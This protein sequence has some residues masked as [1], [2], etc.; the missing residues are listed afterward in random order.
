MEIRIDVVHEGEHFRVVILST[1]E[2]PQ[3]VQGGDYSGP[4]RQESS[5]DAYE[6]EIR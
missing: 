1:T 3:R 4:F 2:K 5:P 6:E